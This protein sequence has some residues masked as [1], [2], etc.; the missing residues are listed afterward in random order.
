MRG[1]RGFSLI[2]VLLIS[3]VV[4]IAVGAVMQIVIVNAGAGRTASAVN[5]EYN[6][7]V[8][9]VERARTW[10]IEN[11][12][13]SVIPPRLSGK[14]SGP[15]TTITTAD[16]LLVLSLDA[17]GGSGAVTTVEIY[18]MWYAASD[19][20]DTIDQAEVNRLP[21]AVTLSGTA[22]DKNDEASP[23]PD[24]GKEEGGGP[25]GAGEAGAYLIRASLEIDGIP[26]GTVDLALIGRRREDP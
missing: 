20:S 22:G 15:G 25:P 9:E 13:N 7:L 2:A 3:L 12:D 19:V 5:R 23:E 18:D 14:P 1:R 24:E 10:I 21:P 17:G 4:L 6:F 8:G 11:L 16:D 26:S